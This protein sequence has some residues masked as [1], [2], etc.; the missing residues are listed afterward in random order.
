MV[1]FFIWVIIAWMTYPDFIENSSHY[2][3]NLY[4]ML[5]RFNVTQYKSANLVTTFQSFINALKKIN[6][7]NP[8]ISA[9][10]GAF[11]KGGF[12]VSNVGYILIALVNSLINPIISIANLAVITG[13]VFVIIAQFLAITTGLATAIFSFVFEPL[14]IYV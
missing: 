14:F 3:L 5:Q 1:M 7:D 8:I 6:I 9:F 13:Y 12:S 4:A 11:N 2:H 10:G